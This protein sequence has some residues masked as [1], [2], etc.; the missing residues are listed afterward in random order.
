MYYFPSKAPHYITAHVLLSLSHRGFLKFN[1]VEELGGLVVE[2]E[3]EGE[4]EGE[5]GRPGGEVVMAKLA[6]R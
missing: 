3:G 6:D 2:I 4:G 5:R 1:R